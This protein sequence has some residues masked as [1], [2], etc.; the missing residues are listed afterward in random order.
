MV[1]KLQAGD[2]WLTE[3]IRIRVVLFR[4]AR[5]A[6]LYCRC[7]SPLPFLYCMWLFCSCTEW[8][9]GPCVSPGSLPRFES[10]QWKGLSLLVFLQ[11]CP[12]EVRFILFTQR[13]KEVFDSCIQSPILVHTKPFPSAKNYLFGVCFQSKCNCTQSS[14]PLNQQYITNHSNTCLPLFWWM[15]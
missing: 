15:L 8:C 1:Q 14:L 9:S 5:R 4:P 6:A 12:A 11:W 2:D 7:Y 13:E 10:F 3:C